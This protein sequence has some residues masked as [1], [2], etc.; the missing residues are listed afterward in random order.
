MAADRRGRPLC[1]NRNSRHTTRDLLNTLAAI[2]GK[3]AGLRSLGDTW[4]RGTA[5]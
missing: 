4:A 1:G 5:A 3:K 2:T